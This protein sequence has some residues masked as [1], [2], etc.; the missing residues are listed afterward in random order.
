MCMVAKFVVVLGCWC[1]I[2]VVRRG[3]GGVGG[4]REEDKRFFNDVS[5]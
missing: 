4:W 5:A 2:F 1:R 3:G